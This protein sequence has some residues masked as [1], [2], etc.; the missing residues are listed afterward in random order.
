MVLQLQVVDLVAS[1]GALRRGIRVVP[2]LEEGLRLVTLGAM[3]L[4][5][6]ESDSLE[7][8]ESWASSLAS[9]LNYTQEQFDVMC[10]ELAK[11]YQKDNGR[12]LIEAAFA[13]L[14]PQPDKV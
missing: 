7:T 11:P 5:P 13:D 12:C 9:E 6:T 1:V 4:G 8:V 3:M 2:C 14:P 10:L